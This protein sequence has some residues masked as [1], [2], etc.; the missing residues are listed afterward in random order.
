MGVAD[1]CLGLRGSDRLLVGR[2]VSHTEPVIS[3]SL[4]SWSH[5][6]V[7]V[8]TAVPLQPL[9]YALS[10]YVVESLRGQ[11]GRIVPDRV[12]PE[13]RVC[14]QADQTFGKTRQRASIPW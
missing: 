9:R 14:G 11:G 3:S 7:S 8:M 12:R 2:C 5:Q 10:R 1:A 6:D 13:V 4:C